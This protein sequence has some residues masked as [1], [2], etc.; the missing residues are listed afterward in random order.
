MSS[1]KRNLNE[2]KSYEGDINFNKHYYEF[3]PLYRYDS[4]KRLR[5]WTIQ[6]RLIKPNNKAAYGQNWN[7]LTDSQIQLNNS[8][9]EPGAKLPGCECQ[10]W[11][12]QGLVNGQISRY[13]PTYS[14]IKNENKKNERNVFQSALVM[15]RS[16][17]LKR[18]EEGDKTNPQLIGVSNDDNDDNTYYWPMLATKFKEEFA[19]LKYPAYVQ[20]KMNGVRM[21]SYLRSNKQ[22]VT[23][24]R[25]LKEIPGIPQIKSELIKPL[26][27]LYNSSEN[28]SVRIDGELF[29]FDIPLNEISGWA[30]NPATNNGPLKVESR[31][32]LEAKKVEERPIQ[33]F[34]FDCFDPSNLDLSFKD[35][36]D[37]LET[38]RDSLSDN[39]IIRS[40]PI[41][42]QIAREMA[43]AEYKKIHSHFQLQVG[44]I[45]TKAHRTE[46]QEFLKD[47]YPF[48]SFNE[49]NSVIES[50]DENCTKYKSFDFK[51]ANNIAFVPT[52]LIHNKAE[53]LALYY[54]AVHQKF[55]G[56]MARNASGIYATSTESKTIKNRSKDLQKL[57]PWYDQ[58]FEIVGFTSGKGRNQNAI[59]W[60]C[61][62]SNGHEFN[63]DPKNMSI[64][65]RKILYAE[66]NSNPSKF[67]D[68]YKGL[69]MTVQYEEKNN[70][71]GI[72]Q[73]AKA[74]GIRNIA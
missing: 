36:I 46:E 28:K 2:F 69:M 50:I 37:Y 4:E 35:R 66:F 74:L 24:T 57:K 68:E 51:I 9:L 17:Y 19:E 12:E 18:L 53:L 30:R 61:K 62:T 31:Q 13:P 38:I 5:K 8:F 23:H 32:L 67:Q 29:G 43:E 45:E 58:E 44:S 20:I 15:M 54:A 3:P 48:Y 27:E 7:L 40:F 10:V 49:W 72:P 47:N 1:A 59:I 42:I 25:D 55:E 22:V 33:Y 11:I 6:C 21:L 56:L 65:Q 70:D 71:T 34:I 14:E 73:R 16:K 26:E 52:M 60:I 64:D 41:N 63:C 39:I